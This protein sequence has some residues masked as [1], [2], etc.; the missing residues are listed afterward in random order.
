MNSHSSLLVKG[1]RIYEMSVYYKSNI[2]NC[3]E[4]I[5]LLAKVKPYKTTSWNLAADIFLLSGRSPVKA[6]TAQIPCSLPGYLNDHTGSRILL[7]NW[8]RPA[9]DRWLQCYQCRCIRRNGEMI[10][11]AFHGKPPM[12][13]TFVDA[14]RR[15]KDESSRLWKSLVD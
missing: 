11:T 6:S 12:N 5:C 13:P 3:M 10:I 1:W 7:I 4:M 2:Y 15:T 14:A 8:I 9:F